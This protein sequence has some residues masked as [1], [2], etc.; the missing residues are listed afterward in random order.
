[1]TTEEKKGGTGS[2]GTAVLAVC[3]H[4]HSQHIVGQSCPTL[5]SNPPETT[6]EKKKCICQR[7]YG[8]ITMQKA[9]CPVNHRDSTPLETG[10]EWE[11]ELPGLVKAF[12][13]QVDSVTQVKLRMFIRS[14]ESSALAQGEKIGAENTRTKMIA[15]AKKAFCSSGLMFTG[16]QI[17][18]VLKLLTL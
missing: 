15:E 2:F 3:P 5:V 16:N 1:M 18:G 4:C 14:I 10:R 13:G 7:V 12:H 17:I 6:E 8:V 11:K 9:W